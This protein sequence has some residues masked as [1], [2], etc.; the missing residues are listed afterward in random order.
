[1]RTISSVHRSMLVGPLSVA[2]LGATLVGAGCNPRYVVGGIEDDGPT[3]VAQGFASC[4]DTLVSG[5]PDAVRGLVF[6]EGYLYY[7]TREYPVTERN[8]RVS[9]AGG[10]PQKVTEDDS[11][12]GVAAA[13]GDQLLLTGVSGQIRSANLDGTNVGTLVEFGGVEPVMGVTATDDEIYWATLEGGIYRR[14]TSGGPVTTLRA[15]SS[16]GYG[17]AATL[18]VDES[19]L[20]FVDERPDPTN[21]QGWAKHVIARMP[22]SGGPEVV[23]YEAAGYVNTMRLTND[24]LYFTDLGFVGNGTDEEIHS[25][26]LVGRISLADP[27]TVEILA[28]DQALPQGLAIDETGVYWGGGFPFAPVDPE[29][30]GGYFS[31]HVSRLSP[32]G[33]T[34]VVSVLTTTFGVVGCDHAVCWFDASTNS[35]KRYKEC[36]E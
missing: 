1:M 24:A 20:Y 32:D 30:P 12:M 15:P 10:A 5:L 8:F 28:E 27:A 25:A 31:S 2:A 36:V 26:G 22:R 14:L 21:A 4:T 16:D 29:L 35:I 9:I 23:L 17:W 19:D 34:T 11:G 13:H 33:A 6:H 7:S 18:Q 3:D